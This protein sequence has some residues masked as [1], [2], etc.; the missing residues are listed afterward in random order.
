M[1]EKRSP[2][3]KMVGRTGLTLALGHIQ[4]SGYHLKQHL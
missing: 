3:R 1:N 2:V 4:S